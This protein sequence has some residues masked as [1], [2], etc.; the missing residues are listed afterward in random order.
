VLAGLVLL[1]IFSIY[2][3]VQNR[4]S[5]L[6]AEIKQRIE[7]AAASRS[8]ILST[9]LEGVTR[10]P[11]Q[12]TES[13]LFKLFVAE[14]D[15][16]IDQRATGTKLPTALRNQLPYMQVAVTSFVKKNGLIGAYLVSRDGRVFLASADAPSLADHQRLGGQA[17]FQSGQRT[18]LPLRAEKDD[19]V[20]DIVFPFTAPQADDPKGAGR[21]VGA[22][23]I[24]IPAKE[25][26]AS[27]LEA[28]PFDQSGGQAR[29]LQLTEE[30][31]SEIVT[32]S[33]PH[34]VPISGTLASELK[35]TLPFGARLDLSGYTAVFS[36]G[37][38]GGAL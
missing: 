38:G 18:V 23:L 32:R 25:K 1:T 33:T 35:D 24:S 31:V 3:L 4:H 14:V 13:N 6:T 36:A 37:G 16:T 21:T 28:G 8:E 19:L 15:L 22:M 20:L 11:D 5:S 10:L 29:L 7:A 2:L 30:T 26:L 27:I 17:V 9:W 34:L 12:F